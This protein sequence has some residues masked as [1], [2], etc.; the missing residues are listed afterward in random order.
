MSN[1]IYF[2][3]LLLKFL[4]QIPLAI[5]YFSSFFS[6][7][8][9]CYLVCS[10]IH[11]FGHQL[12]RQLQV[13]GVVFSCTGAASCCCR[14]WVVLLMCAGY[15]AGSPGVAVRSTGSVVF[16]CCC[17]QSYVAYPFIAFVVFGC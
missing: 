9:S 16:D 2:Q 14:V 7:L 15:S 1:R 11:K 8:F 5:G 13:F 17:V 12:S 6:H 10:R 3:V 4:I